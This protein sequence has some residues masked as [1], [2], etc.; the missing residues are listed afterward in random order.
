MQE[1]P[2]LKIVYLK[3]ISPFE[4]K[5]P[6]VLRIKKDEAHLHDDEN[7]YYDDDRDGD[8]NDVDHDDL[9]ENDDDNDQ[10]WK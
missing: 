5:S 9:N 7:E 6:Q 1:T 8:D 2:Q 3:V 4:S 10:R